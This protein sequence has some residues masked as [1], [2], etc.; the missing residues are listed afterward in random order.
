MT[1][2]IERFYHRWRVMHI[3]TN[4]WVV[5]G[6]TRRDAEYILNRIPDLSDS[7]KA[8]E[9]RAVLQRLASLPLEEVDY[10]TYR[11]LRAKKRGQR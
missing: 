2:R 4:R 10:R 3:A 5:S 7:P 9:V 1:Y 11:V 6:A 8:D